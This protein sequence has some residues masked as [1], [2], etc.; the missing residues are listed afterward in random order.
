MLSAKL[1]YRPFFAVVKEQSM[2]VDSFQVYVFVFCSVHSLRKLIVNL[3]IS[4]YLILKTA[5]YTALL[6][7]LN[8]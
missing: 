8:I 5:I 2:P 1:I 7:K 4:C 6:S 3:R